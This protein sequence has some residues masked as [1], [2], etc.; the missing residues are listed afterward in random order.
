MVL[1]L[2]GWDMC[3]CTHGK[4]YMYE[5]PGTWYE[6]SMCSEACKMLLDISIFM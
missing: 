4:E 1:N 6:Y 5:Y 2:N 3:Y